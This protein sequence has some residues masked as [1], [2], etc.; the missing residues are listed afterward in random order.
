MLNYLFKMYKVGII[1]VK[2]VISMYE[3][4]LGILYPNSNGLTKV[5]LVSGGVV[6]YLMI[7]N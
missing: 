7:M 4:V 1:K 5:I 6:G 2:I 3:Y